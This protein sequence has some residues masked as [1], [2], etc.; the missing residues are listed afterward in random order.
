V[1]V[2]L[3]ANTAASMVWFRL[4]FLR[5]LRERG[6]DVWVLA[7]ADRTVPEIEATGVRFLPLSSAQGWSTE[8]DR[9][10]SYLDAAADLA[11]AREVWRACRDVRAE[12]VLSYTAKL[13]LLVPPAARAAGVGAVHAMVTG[14]GGT[15]HGVSV[16]A[17]A[18]RAGMHAAVALAGRLSTSIVVLNRDNLDEVRGLVPDDRLFL[19]DGEGVDT[20]RFDAP[21]PAA[22]G[23]VTFLLVAR[24]VHLKG[25]PVF[26]AAARRVRARHPDARFRI[27]GGADPAH[28]DAVDPAEVEA[29][30]REGVVELL[31]HVD[32]VRSV[33][34]DCDVY[35]LPSAREGLSMS[36]M[37]AMAMRRPVITTDA[38]GNRETVEPGVNGWRVPWNDEVALADAME[39]AIRRRAELPAIG[40]ASRQRVLARFDHRVVNAHLLAHLG[41]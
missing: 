27:A 10:G 34:R 41:L 6:H 32:D 40:E 22:S 14:L 36:T 17:R 23:P 20:D 31:G 11:T 39:D 25:V 12:L 13:A 3:V 8:A 28:P 5:R 19:L 35:V 33:Y 16:K 29:W 4:P 7:P 24:L 38:P 18:L 30:R 15:S 9:R 21:A 2:L 1:R 26:V 37:E